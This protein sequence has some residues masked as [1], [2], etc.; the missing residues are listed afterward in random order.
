M[1]SRWI[2]HS[3]GQGSQGRTFGDLLPTAQSHLR[4]I[5]PSVRISQA[6]PVLV[7]TK[8]ESV[9]LEDKSGVVFDQVQLGLGWDMAGS[10]PIDLDASAVC[11]SDKNQMVTS[12]TNFIITLLYKF[13]SF[14]A[15][16]V[17]PCSA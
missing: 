7:L 12:Q 4:D 13:L 14:L 2:F 3:I 15:L 6:S 16:S 11:F 1:F 8:G 9:R 10:Q 17:L 5:I